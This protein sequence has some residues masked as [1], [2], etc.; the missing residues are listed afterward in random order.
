MNKLTAL[1]LTLAF[2][3]G[4]ASASF[5]ASTNDLVPQATDLSAQEMS[6]TV[7]ASRIYW[8][9]DAS[10]ANVFQADRDGHSRTIR[11]GQRWTDIGRHN[12][13][14]G[15]RVVIQCRTS[16]GVFRQ[17]QFRKPSYSIGIWCRK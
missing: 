14:T 9:T 15:T 13:R 6:S 17:G 2:S 3:V 10:W 4:G 5:A 1:A 11:R 8:K 16:T 7:G 12:I